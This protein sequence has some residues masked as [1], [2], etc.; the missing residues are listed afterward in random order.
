M[1]M[2]SEPDWAEIVA[3]DI[4]RYGEDNQGKET[5]HIEIEDFCVALKKARADGLRDAAAIV[6]AHKSAISDLLARADEIEAGK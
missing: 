5:R 6:A 4:A 2:A 1:G 3:D